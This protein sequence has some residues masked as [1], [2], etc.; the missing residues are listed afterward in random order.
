M[1]HIITPALAAVA[2]GTQAHAQLFTAYSGDEPGAKSWLIDVETGEDTED[3]LGAFRAL[4][5]DPVGG[6]IFGSGGRDLVVF[7]VDASGETTQDGSPRIVVDRNG[8]RLL[9]ITSLAWGN[10]K[11]YAAHSGLGDAPGGLYVIEEETRIETMRFPQVPADLVLPITDL[12]LTRPIDLVADGQV[13]GLTFDTDRGE[14]LIGV[15]KYEE[16][17]GIDEGEPG[18]ADERENLIGNDILSLDPET[19][20]GTL[21]SRSPS[22]SA[23]VA[24]TGWPT[25]TT[26]SISTAVRRATR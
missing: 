18:P 22:P 3:V 25:G 4:A 26:E 9:N 13:Q 11:L 7:D 10:G 21:A 15:E 19:G 16:V 14:L 20:A 5:H 24:L 6:R 12:P 2:V 17:D 8:D 23:R 1:R